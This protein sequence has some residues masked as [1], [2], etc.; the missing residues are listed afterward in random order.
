[1]ILENTKII[2]SLKFEMCCFYLSI[3]F[4]PFCAIP[5]RLA[6]SSFNMGVHLSIYPILIGMAFYL[7]RIINT[8]SFLVPKKYIIFLFSIFCAHFLSVLHGLIIFPAWGEVDAGQFDKLLK[9]LSWSDSYLSVDEDSIGKVWLSTKLIMKTFLDFLCTYGCALWIVSLFKVN[10]KE[11]LQCF[12]RGLIGSAILCCGYSIIECLHLFGIHE[13]SQVLSKINASIFDIGSSH[14]WWPTLFGSNR[15]RSLFAEPSFLTL[16]L[17]VVIPVSI[18]YSM[19]IKKNSLLWKLLPSMLLVMMITTN[20]KTGMG[21]L[22]AEAIA[23]IFFIIMGRKHLWQARDIKLYSKSITKALIW[24]FVVLSVGIGANHA[25]QHRYS[26]VYDVLGIENNHAITIAVKNTG[27]TIWDKADRYGLTASLTDE[28]MKICGKIDVP[29]S[30]TLRS[31]DSEIVTIDLPSLPEYKNVIIGLTKSGPEKAALSTQ[32]AA[33]L[34]L[35]K[36][37]DGMLKVADEVNRLSSSMLAI[38]S[39]TD[40]SNQQRYG[41]MLVEFKIGLQHPLLG[42]GGGGLKQAYIVPNIP[43]SLKSNHE[44]QL[45]TKMQQEKGLF[46]SGF[47]TLSEYSNQF[48]SYGILGFLLFL[49]PSFYVAY[50]LWYTREKWLNKVNRLF[51]PTVAFSAAYFGLMVS[52]IGGNTMQIYIYWIFLGVMIGWCEILNNKFS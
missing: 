2:K 18:Y 13:A 25:L 44:V 20:S 52:Y 39:T 46:R 6:L 34:L 51:F 9:I 48:A 33:S 40:G 41:M 26:I 10:Q 17:S 8:R 31:G 28:D 23:V 50:E 37:D 49:L 32:G 43:E 21:I 27:W 35:Q 5:K 30:K 11:T 4:I 19:V 15:V 3:L 1:M 12:F 47:P 16:Y 7:Y 42:V 45:W 38:A 22:L 24:A 29:I 14:G 36:Q